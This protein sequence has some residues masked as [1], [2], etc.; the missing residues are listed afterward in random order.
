MSAAEPLDA[1]ARPRRSRSTRRHLHPVAKTEPTVDIP[2][3]SHRLGAL[4]RE[5]RDTW[6]TMLE[7]DAAAAGR[8]GHAGKLVHRA[9]VVLSDH[10]AIY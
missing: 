9:G 10:S 5:L 8:L 1:P 4:E 7:L 2:G 3:L 6:T